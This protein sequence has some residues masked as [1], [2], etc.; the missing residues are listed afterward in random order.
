MS[1]LKGTGTSIFKHLLARKIIKVELNQALKLDKHI[2]IALSEEALKE[3]FKI[4]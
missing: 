2:E 3:E 1:L 4:S